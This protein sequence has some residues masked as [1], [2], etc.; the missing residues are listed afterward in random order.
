MKDQQQLHPS[1]ESWRETEYTRIQIKEDIL[2]CI[3]INCPDMT[4]DIARH[5]VQSRMAAAEGKSYPC[6][7]DMRDMTTATSE[8][9]EYFAK[10][11]AEGVNAGALLIGS[12]VT[13]MLANL[14][15]LVNRPKTPTRM[16]TDERVAREWLK[17]YI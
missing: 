15:M 14:F 9:R 10:E 4:L 1:T 12:Q 6:L 17:K 7:V 16:F 8:A 13:K 5:C 2:H 11:G 3:F